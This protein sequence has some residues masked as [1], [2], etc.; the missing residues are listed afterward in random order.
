MR[1]SRHFGYIVCVVLSMS[2]FRRCYCY[3]PILVYCLL[4]LFWSVDE[5][6]KLYLYFFVWCFCF[7]Q[8]D[9]F[10]GA[11]WVEHAGGKNTDSQSVSPFKYLRVVG[12]RENMAGHIQVRSYI[13]C[14]VIFAGQTCVEV[15]RARSTNA[16]F[17]RYEHAS[18]CFLLVVS[19]P[20]CSR[21][22]GF[23]SHQL[24]N[25]GSGARISIDTHIKIVAS[26]SPR[27]CHLNPE[28]TKRRLQRFQ[29]RRKV[30][31]KAGG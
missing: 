11:Q 2:L 14:L 23:G 20:R 24:E 22:I 21:S 15:F 8:C 12:T 4:F 27:S 29:E 17:A 28:V 5:R 7:S 18:L 6:K 9:H 25:I 10:T 19:S 30:G 3:F 16:A 31:L 1:L 13:Y 26:I